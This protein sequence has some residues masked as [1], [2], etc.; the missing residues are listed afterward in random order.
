MSRLPVIIV[1]TNCLSGVTTWSEHLRAALADHPRYDVRLLHIGEHGA[2]EENILVPDVEAAYRV[3]RSMAPLILLP[4]YKWELYLA[5]CEPGVS[6]L[7]MCHADS[8]EQYY[9]PL[10]WYEPMISQFIGV[11]PECSAHIKQRLAFR[12]DD[13]TTLPYGIPVPRYLHRD[14]QIDPL[15]IVYAGRVTQLQ[16]RVMD[17][18]P[19][20]ENL[21]R[22]EVRFVFDVV[23]DGDYLEPLRAEIA[24]RFPEACVKFHGRRPF[25]EMPDVW[26]SHDIF[27]QTSDFEG[28]SISLLEAMAYGVA[29]V[30]TAATSGVSGVIHEGENGFIV[31]V[32][33]MAA[34]A[35]AI[36]R[37]AAEPQRLAAI[38]AAARDASQEYSL[39]RYGQ[40]FARV[41]D[42]IVQTPKLENLAARYG[43]FAGCH[44]MF[45][46][47]A[48][49]SQLQSRI[50]YL[51]QG[52]IKRLVARL[53]G[54]ERSRRLRIA[55]RVPGAIWQQKNKAA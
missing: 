46:Q 22:L 26:T 20:F 52:P 16:K 29:P 55:G 27:V 45:K 42:R 40:K 31:P 21:Q 28:T 44:P 9:R 50:A 15:R 38:G 25:H 14:Y 51:E 24:A 39:D 35:Q 19:L 6:C 7:G 43:M 18:V 1:G 12:A 11:S 8:D 32:G 34:M 41:L 5:G 30:V 49:I 3:V 37:L 48:I 53:L 2:G 13:V 23:G 36:A 33:D 17:F 10:S 4:N 47:G 54:R